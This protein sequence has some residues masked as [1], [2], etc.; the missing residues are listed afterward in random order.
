MATEKVMLDC[1]HVDEADMSAVDCIARQVLDAR[2]EGCECSL[3]GASGELLELIAF[4]GLDGVLRAEVQRKPEQR[5]EL[6][7]VE[8][9]GEPA[10]PPA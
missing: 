4:A 1:A 2:R 3:R 6:R 9:E 7:R 10:D 8:E 5:K